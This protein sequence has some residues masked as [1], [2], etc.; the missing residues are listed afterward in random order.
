MLNFSL[1]ENM[2]RK[3]LSD[4]ETAL[5]FW[6]LNREFGKSFEE[7]GKITGYSAGHICNFVRMTGMFDDHEKFMKDPSV[8]ADMQRITEHHSRILLRIENPETRR[9]LLRLIV[10]D[11]LSVR[12][13][14]RIVAKFRV[15]FKSEHG[16]DEVPSSFF[17]EQIQR[18]EDPTDSII[19]SLI[20]EAELPHKGDFEAFQNL[21]AFEKGF[22][23]YSN[24]PPFD[25]FE[26]NRALE[27]ERNW[28]FSEGTRAKRTVRD[29]RIQF[30]S[31]V[32]LATLSVDQGN[33][34]GSRQTNDSER[35]TVLFVNIDGS[36]KIVHEHWSNEQRG[37]EASPR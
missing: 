34:K 37:L 5:S 13:L 20:A 36:W 24:L 31:S 6:R 10:S 12:D 8:L 11:D 27:H 28:F 1:I 33:K 15:W 25:R 18:V 22:S 2:E 3:N 29:V 14:Q 21:H 23:L 7:I 17:E 19:R 16:G 35:G 9:R 26:G 4:F 32:A 30:Y